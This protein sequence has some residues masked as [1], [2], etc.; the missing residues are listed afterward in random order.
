MTKTVGMIDPSA[1]S[2]P[3]VCRENPLNADRLGILSRR[4][5]KPLAS[6]VSEWIPPG[7]D[8]SIAVVFRVWGRSLRDGSP[9]E[10]REA[11]PM[12]KTL[13]ATS[14]MLFVSALIACAGASTQPSATY[15]GRA[16]P[17]PPVVLVYPF[18]TSPDEVVADNLG[19][20]F[21]R[22][23]PRTPEEKR[24]REVSDKLA[25][26]IVKAL[27]QRGIAAERG[28]A[29]APVPLHAVMLKGQ[30]ITIDPG[31]RMARMV[32]GFGAGTEE[33]RVRAQAV[34]VLE[35]G[36]LRLQEGLAEA[37]G[38][39]MPGMAGPGVASAAAGKATM[40]ILS[41]GTNIVQE[42]KGGLDA[43]AANLAREIAEL[44]AEF[45]ARQ[46]WN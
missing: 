38:D 17:R 6:A 34:Q 29:G 1:T 26:E 13:V 32:I 39:K 10:D 25:N 30:F 40:I 4:F 12:R 35:N 33:L 2:H 20:D 7:A 22:P 43:A 5:E 3:R 8:A 23:T 41:A 28:E 42:V 14:L 46:G 31:N 19:S 37:H 15:E 11:Y 18:A 21:R 9:D 24:A 44:A 45:Y 16:L 36:R 27:R